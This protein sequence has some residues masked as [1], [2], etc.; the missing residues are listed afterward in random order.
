MEPQH[1]VRTV[2][3]LPVC[4][5]RD[6]GHGQRGQALRSAS[7][8]ARTLITDFPIQG[9]LD[10]LV[11]RIVEILPIT[12]AGV[13][14]ITP[15]TAPH[16]IA[17]SD[18]AALRYEQLQTLV[19][20]GPCVAAFETGEAVSV[21]DLSSDTRFPLF[22]PAA[23]AAG[24]AAVFTFPLRHSDGR[25]GALDLY[26]DS[27]G[28]LDEGDMAAAQTLAD[29]AAA[30]LLNAQA[31]DDAQAASDGFHH[32]ALHDPLTGLPNRLLLHERLEHAT[33]RA[34]RS[35]T[36]SAILFADIDQFKHVNDTYGHT[37]GD[38]L[39]VSVAN[40][41]TALM[42]AEDTLVRF[43]GDEFVILCEDLHS[44]ADAERLVERIKNTFVEPFEVGDRRITI[45]LSVGIAYAG[46]GDD[47]DRQ[48]LVEADLA[49]YNAKRRRDPGPRVGAGRDTSNRR[50]DS[51]LE[52]DLRAALAFDQLGVVYQPIV[53]V[54]DQQVVGVEALLRW[55]HPTRGAIAPTTIIAIAERSDL[56]DDIG[57]W[58]LQRACHDHG[59]WKA[60][61]PDLRLDLAVNISARQLAGTGLTAAVATILSATGMDIGMLVL[62]IT[63]S[64]LIDNAESSIATLTSLA[65]LGI[66]LALDDFGSG[67]SSLHYLDRLP[68]HEVKIDQQFV[69]RLTHGSADTTVIAGITTIAHGLGLPVVAEGVETR[70]QH[71]LIRSLECDYAQ[72]YLYAR[73]MTAAALERHLDDL[74]EHQRFPLPSITAPVPAPAVPAL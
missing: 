59:R 56:I 2:C 46:P 20:Q 9:I 17:A 41:L 57:G 67:Y 33:L 73:P 65:D 29:V 12:S 26:R 49:M 1:P 70:A 62:E 38:E 52:T 11:T 54:D 31:R 35:H 37:A 47:V 30:Y 5:A 69:A 14:L 48:L 51:R 7:E 4:S 3:G 66:R 74:S 64:V 34:R 43:S 71:D 50:A 21:A 10:H 15:G 22:A 60:H 23:V 13:T 44:V 55:N 16:Y 25:L 45:S 68:V 6:G 18:D 8:F 42:R 40:R 27:P 32:D 39:L 63:E 24:L 61:R 58:V 53:D 19:G 36:H 28:A 72:G